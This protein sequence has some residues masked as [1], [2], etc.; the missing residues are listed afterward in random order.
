MDMCRQLWRVWGYPT[1]DLFVS[2]LNYRT[3]DFVSPFQDPE[4]IATDAFLYNWD[5]QDLYAFPPTSFH[6]EGAQQASGLQEHETYSDRSFLA[7]EGVVSGPVAG[8][9][10]AIPTPSIAKGPSEAPTHAQVPPWSL[11][12]SADR[13]ETVQRYLRYR[14]FSS[15][16]AQFLANG[17]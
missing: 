17:K 5:Y 15:R 16:V 6:Q 9:D 1:V 2:R 11:R 10:R 3:P 12:A 14:G 7:T 8:V 4:A 13:V